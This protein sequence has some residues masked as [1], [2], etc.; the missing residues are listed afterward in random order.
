MWGTTVRGRLSFSKRHQLL[1]GKTIRQVGK[2]DPKESV[3]DKCRLSI[4]RVGKRQR[5]GVQHL[6]DVQSAALG[7]RVAAN[8]F[9]VLV[10]PRFLGNTMDMSITLPILAPLYAPHGL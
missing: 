3:G 4:M 9:E 8:P 1:L 10:V 2:N 6:A 7:V 5:I